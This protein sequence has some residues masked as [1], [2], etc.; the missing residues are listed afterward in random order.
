MDIGMQDIRNDNKCYYNPKKLKK[1]LKCF[2]QFK[3]YKKC[4]G[5][6]SFNKY[7]EN[8]SIL[9]NIMFSDGICNT[10]SYYVRLTAFIDAVGIL[11]AELIVRTLES[12]D[13]NW[14]NKIPEI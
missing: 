5:K 11:E 7:L 9:Y 13:K 12:V 2:I 14:N 1:S 4:H 10:S 3:E 6:N 8:L